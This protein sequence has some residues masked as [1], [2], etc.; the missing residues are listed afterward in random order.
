[1]NISKPLL[2]KGGSWEREN[3]N[4]DVRLDNAL[5]EKGLLRKKEAVKNLKGEN[6][7]LQKALVLP[8]KLKFVY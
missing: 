8:N 5:V 2:V 4:S 3:W 1:M 7:G 6:W